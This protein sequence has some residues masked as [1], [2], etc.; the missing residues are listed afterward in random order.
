MNS[1]T[2]ESKKTLFTAGYEGKT[3][4]EF[5]DLLEKNS[6]YTVIDVRE[7]PLSRKKGFSKKALMKLCEEHHVQ[8]SHFKDLGSPKPLRDK[9]KQDGNWDYFFRHYESHLKLAEDTIEFVASLLKSSTILLL[10]YE[11]EPSLCHR[12]IVAS[13]LNNQTQSEGIHL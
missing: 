1:Q 6:I 7:Y 5:L 12:S 3:T 8:Y 11:S 13:W 10:C 2:N 9:V 4:A